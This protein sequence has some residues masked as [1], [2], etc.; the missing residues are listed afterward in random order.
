MGD[1]F[2]LEDALIILQRRFLYFLIPVI[3]LAPIGIITV[4]LLP[5]KYTAQGTILVESQQIPTDF[6]RSTI[7]AY[8]QERIQTIRQRVMT[9]NRLL[10]VAAE[11]ELFPRALGLSETER[12]KRMRNNLKVDLIT[13]TANRGSGD[14]TIAF[15]VAYT[16]QDPR[17]SYLVANKFMTLFLDED[18]RTR[19][20]GA[21]N[22]TEFFERETT[23]LRNTVAQL[24]DRVSKYKAENSGALPEHLNMNLN[25]LE[26]LQRELSTAQSSISQLEE[27]RRFL[28]NQLISGTNGD[29]SMSA[30]LAQLE[31]DLARLRATY[32]D[33]YPEV[34]A[35]RDEIAALKS[36]MAP[37]REITRLR[38][39][40]TNAEDELT[41]VERAAEPDAEA[42]A[43]AEANVEKA[44]DALSQR[45]TEETRKG[46]TDI[47]GVQL[48]GRIAV[49][50]NRIRML[51]KQVNST[52]QQISDLESRIE[53][54]PEVERGLAALTRD[55]ENV[56][57]EYQDILNKQQDAQLAENL[58]ESQQTE[59]FSILEPALNPERPS[60]P[61]RAKLIF[62]ALIFALGAGGATALGVELVKSRLRGRSHVANV[63]DGQPIAVIP[64][65]HGENE[66]RL[67]LPF[68]RKKSERHR[69]KGRMLE[70]EPA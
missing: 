11:Y 37:S 55:Y 64:Y 62:V 1:E 23:R 61:D 67:R 68:S 17:K 8:A 69:A 20:A 4:M 65:I 44:R 47:A 54:T 58:E 49:V 33:S 66:R 24:E 29:N 15:T 35:K 60:S 45:I 3:I 40:L 50:E 31:S 70:P 38:D 14:G 34:A 43:A 26:R 63:L 9:R 27:E 53:R 10:E 41:S 22:T 48:E 28:E 39:A 7:N 56:F 12:V 42:I 36:R 30:Q 19:T 13:T 51:N 21:S 59:K 52:T 32:R 46:S 5:A 18:V 2:T 6:V 16:D 25:M 57:Q